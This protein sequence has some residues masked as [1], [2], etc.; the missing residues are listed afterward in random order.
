MPLAWGEIY[1]M[2][3]PG[4]KQDSITK[5]EQ[6]L[7]TRHL[8]VYWRKKYQES[9]CRQHNILLIKTDQKTVYLWLEILYQNL[10][11]FVLQVSNLL[12]VDFCLQLAGIAE[13]NGWTR[14]GKKKC[15]NFLWSNK[16]LR[17]MS[18]V[19]LDFQENEPRQL[20]ENLN[21]CFKCSLL[22]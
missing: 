3:K 11:H 2:Q 14:P 21:Y 19:K 20:I 15:V 6:V 10:I 17:K 16:P 9:T 13:L 12:P 1:N 5:Q 4:G 22:K 8:S 7:W 18:Q